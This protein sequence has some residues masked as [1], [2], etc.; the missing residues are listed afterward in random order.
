MPSA[1]LNIGRETHKQK[2][3]KKKKKNGERKGSL[4]AVGINYA[5]ENKKRC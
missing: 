4:K 5:E 3:V 2:T 1:D